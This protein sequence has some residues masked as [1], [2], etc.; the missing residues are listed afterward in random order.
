MT[1][2]D[3]HISWADE[4]LKHFQTSCGTTDS[5]A[6]ADLICDLGHLAD[7]RGQSFL[8]E[9][10]RGV[11]H[12]LAEREGVDATFS[13]AEVKIIVRPLMRREPDVKWMNFDVNRLSI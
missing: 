9:V 10:R 13:E 11:C 6:I 1:D 12:W 5:H 8:E 3:C 7:R 4:A 2:R